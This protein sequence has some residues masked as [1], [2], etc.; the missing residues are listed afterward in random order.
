MKKTFGLVST[1]ALLAAAG[2]ASA[3]VVPTDIRQ[4][5]GS[6]T[7]ELFTEELVAACGAIDGGTRYPALFQGEF[8]YI[9]GG[10]TGGGQAIAGG[11]QD[12]SPMSRG[13]NAA[14]GCDI[15]IAAGP[16]GENLRTYS[17][18]G[19]G[20]NAVTGSE[21]EPWIVALDGMIV[22]TSAGS[23]NRCDTANPNADPSDI[24]GAAIAF[25]SAKSF[26]VP[27]NPAYVIANWRDALRVMYAGAENTRVATAGGGNNQNA[28]NR[29]DRCNSP[30]RRA[31]VA[32]WDNIIQ[33]TADC[34]NVAES[35]G[36]QN[37]ARFGA[38]GVRHLLRRDDLSGTTDTF[39]T[40]LGLAGVGGNIQNGNLGINE[41]FCNGRDDEDR[42]PIRINVSNVDANP[43]TC[44]NA[45]GGPALAGA[46]LNDEVGGPSRTSAAGA[47]A[48]CG[49]SGLV[50]AIAVPIAI[51]T[52]NQPPNAANATGAP[53]NRRVPTLDELYPANNCTTGQFRL[54]RPPRS[55][56]PR[57]Y[58]GDTDVGGSVPSRYGMVDCTT[59]PPGSAT[60][61][62]DPRCPDGQ[63]IQ[64]QDCLTPTF[65]AD[66]IGD[67]HCINS[68]ENVVSTAADPDGLVTGF[69]PDGRVWNRYLRA[70]PPGTGPTTFGDALN[71]SPVVR[72]ER[73]RDVQIAEYRMRA[74]MATD[75][76]AVGSCAY[77]QA[78]QTCRELDATQAIGCLSRT[79]ECALGFAGREAW[80][81]AG[82]TAMLLGNDPNTDGGSSTV[83]QG[84]LAIGPTA[85]G[86]SSPDVSCV[87]NT[88]PFL[89]AIRVPQGG[90]TET[91]RYQLSR[92]LYVNSIVGFDNFD[93]VGDQRW[94]DADGAVVGTTQLVR[95]LPPDSPDLMNEQAQLA[96][97]L[98]GGTFGDDE[99]EAA[100]LFAIE[101]A[102]FV[103]RIPQVATC[104]ANVEG[105]CLAGD[106][107]C[108]EFDEYQCHA[109]AVP[110][111]PCSDDATCVTAFGAGHACGLVAPANI[112]VCRVLPLGASPRIASCPPS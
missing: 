16:L 96:A 11:T 19:A 23:A 66:G 21:V 72:N 94:S 15:S 80:T 112:G 74:R 41:P 101:Q 3:Q 103:S 14:E 99:E 70:A 53:G 110:S 34:G 68:R 95:A 12:L 91:N 75:V 20:A 47:S 98:A 5:R 67:A 102:G 54:R 71:P 52:T 81:V 10:S 86:P 90:T 85:C 93:A 108:E 82:A 87:G 50:S 9:G 1:A 8:Q 62:W 39:L 69:T 48:R 88:N 33:G 13:P 37:A 35:C 59:L 65:G 57:S 105:G 44:N 29:I 49:G 51:G 28:S 45:N 40:L 104:N 24:F 109:A 36:T 111:T 73:G 89:D 30:V 27:G 26:A 107:A 61:C 97:C 106:V 22:G 56:E 83:E 7:L 58:C 6:D 64:F 76:G 63:P 46:D 78:T 4:F 84:T 42:D 38:G 92:K 2:S 100:V 79:S 77:T 25:N 17:A 31:M 60:P 55:S 32:D 43:N 18:N